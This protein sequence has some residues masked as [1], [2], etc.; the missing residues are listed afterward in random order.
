MQKAN[1][2]LQAIRKLGVQRI[3]LTRVYRSLFCEELYLAAYDKIRRNKGALTPGTENDT[4]D[5]FSITD[6][7]TVIELLR[8]E[9]FY[10]RPSRRTQIPKKSKGKRP[11]G[12]PNFTE[13][14][15]QEVLRMI[16][17]AYYEPRFRASSHGFRPER[18]CHTALTDLKRKFGGTTWFIEDDIKGCFDNIDHE[19]LMHLLSRDIHDGRLLNLIRLG[20]QARY[21]EEW[22]YHE[23]HSGTPQG[24]VLSPLLSN[25]VLHELDTFIEDVLVPQYSRGK[26]RRRN[27]Q[28]QRLTREMQKAQQINNTEL[29]QK[30]TQQR[31]QIPC[32]DSDDPNFR[33]LKY[34]RYADDFILGFIGPKSEAESIKAAIG[35]FLQDKLRLTMSVEKTLITHAR[36][37]HARFLGY[38]VS[39]QQANDKLARH[40]KTNRQLRSINGTIRLGVPYGLVTEQAKRYQ[41]RGKTVGEPTLLFHSDVQIIETFQQRFR[42]IAEYYKY[43]VDRICLHKL[44][45]IMEMALV[46]TLAEKYQISVRQVYRKYRSIL[47]VDDFDYKTLAVEVPT[48]R[49][50][51]LIYWGA[52]PLKVVKVGHEP[53]TDRKPFELKYARTDLIQRLQA[54]ICELCGSQNNIEVHHVRKLADLKR[55]WAGRKEKPKWVVRMIAIQ[56]KTLVVC[57][58]CHVDI[59]A[60]RPTPSSREEVRESRVQ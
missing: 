51:R 34:V 15:V 48:A 27:P 6:V 42:G 10:F 35:R 24:G 1:Q 5:G 3:P 46:K 29:L 53:I 13:K 33:R 45:Y 38:A 49:G 57:H 2:I 59:H 23:T 7:R 20:L 50:T 9:R 56:R 41:R 26:D 22:E 25:I 52:V 54:N 40:Q 32:G 55:R 14:L 18:G 16:L 28:F 17:E 47:R 30:L 43:A 4:A 11:L 8:T 60:G 36:T 58:Q 12:I 19:V 21:V 31:R 39:V 44:K 37:E